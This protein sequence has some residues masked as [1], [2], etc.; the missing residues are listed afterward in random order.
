MTSHSD[1]LSRGIAHIDAKALSTVVHV[2]AGDGRCIDAYRRRPPSRLVLVEGDPAARR[3]LAVAAATLAGTEVRGDI[4]GAA[5][6]SGEWIDCSV[7]R[8][9]GLHRPARL[10]D[11]YPGLGTRAPLPVAVRSLCDVLADCAVPDSRRMST[12]LVLDLP[13]ALRAALDAVPPSL[14]DAFGWILLRA[15]REALHE[16]ADVAADVLAWLDDHYYRPQWS[17]TE[18]DPL[19]E[20]HLLHLDT[21]GRRIAR[22]TADLATAARERLAA[23]RGLAEL[24]SRQQQLTRRAEAAEAAEKELASLK[25]RLQSTAERAKVADDMEMLARQRNEQIN[26]LKKELGE[27]RQTASATS[28]LNLLRDAD[29]RD[30]QARYVTLREPAAAAP[31]AAIAGDEPVRTL[32]HFAC[33]GGTLISKCIASMPNVQLLSE[34]DPLSDA[35]LGRNRNRFAPTDMVALLRQSSRGAEPALLVKVFQDGLRA[36][37]RDV[38]GRGQRLVL[39]DHAHSH[40]CLG[41]QVPPRPTLRDM[42]LEVA[43]VLSLVTVRHPIDSVASVQKNWGLQFEPATLEEY[44]LRYAAFL[45]AYPGVRIV[46][47]EDFVRSPREVMRIVCDELR[48][49]FFEDFEQVFPSIELSGDSGRRSDVIALPERRAEAAAMMEEA[50]RAPAF[51]ALCERLGYGLGDEAAVRDNEHVSVQAKRIA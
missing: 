16:G 51:V 23:E 19:W 21:A 44:A 43:P 24:R 3:R 25:T 17:D 22:L 4:V 18:S 38:V 34:V 33:T 35:Q 14:L 36:V 32:H 47:Y 8:F 39:R 41:R 31:R 48:L 15:P 1:S 9:S 30:L 26:R 37:I 2:G 28:R 5:A 42:V 40:F 13:G 45:D 29:L 7:R 20:T 12:A 46:R 10:M 11:Y 49:P 6:G 50:L 27:A